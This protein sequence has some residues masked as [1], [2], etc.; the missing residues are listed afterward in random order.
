M[1]K[2]LFSHSQVVIFI[3]LIYHGTIHTYAANIMLHGVLLS[4]SKRHLDFG[5]GFYTTP[6]LEFA[7]AT[8]ESH[9]NSFNYFNPHQPV[10]PQVLAFEFDRQKAALLSQLSF[11]HPDLPWAQFIIANR[12]E[13]PAVHSSYLHNIDQKFDLVFGPVADGKGTIT[14]MVEQVNVG[15]LSLEELNFRAIAPATH[16]RWGTQISFHTKEA[17]ACIQLKSVV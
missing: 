3:S 13:N 17:L 10:R 2:F 8:A 11:R 7:R 16:S 4:K 1:D 5:P 6:E 9:A 15:A 12:C 14:P